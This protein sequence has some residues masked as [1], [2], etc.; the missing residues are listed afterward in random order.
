MR[1]NDKNIY[2][3][4]RDYLIFNY[5]NTLFQEE[6]NSFFFKEDTRSFFLLNNAFSLCKGGQNMVYIKLS[7]IIDDNEADV[8]EFFNLKYNHTIAIKLRDNKENRKETLCIS[9]IGE[10]LKLRT[11]N[12]SALFYHSK[13]EF[14][15]SYDHFYFRFGRIN[16][17]SIYHFKRR[18]DWVIYYFFILH[19]YFL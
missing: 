4:L 11:Y 16:L 5:K 9:Y 18:Y 17:I 14:R 3:N 13:K 8:Y 2:G 12:L 19:V 7:H 10:D 6:E 15:R 1:L